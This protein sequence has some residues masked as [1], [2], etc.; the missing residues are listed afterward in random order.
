MCMPVNACYPSVNQKN[1]PSAG[2]SMQIANVFKT[3]SDSCK[4]KTDS[5]S[6]KIKTDSDSCIT[7]RNFWVCMCLPVNACHPSVN[8]E[9]YPSTGLSMQIANVFKTDSD[10]CKTKLIVT[11]A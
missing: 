7:K 3:D 2:L 10:S 1:Y 9:N 6:C 11:V 4:N 8:Q 5:D